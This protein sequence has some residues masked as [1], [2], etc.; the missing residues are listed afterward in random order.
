MSKTVI[1]FS[2]LY[3]KMN[4]VKMQFHSEPLTLFTVVYENLKM[5]FHHP[6]NQNE[7]SSTYYIVYYYN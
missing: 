4:Y 6:H 1:S 2:S 3:L 5:N 7:K